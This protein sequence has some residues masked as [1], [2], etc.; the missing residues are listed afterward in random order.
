MASS[1]QASASSAVTVDESDADEAKP[2]ATRCPFCNDTFTE[3]KL[4]PCVHR[5]C[6]KCLVTWFES[7][8]DNPV[9]PVCKRSAITSSE[10]RKITAD[11]NKGGKKSEGEG[12]SD[13]GPRLAEAVVDTLPTDTVLAVLA[14][15]TRK[16][17]PPHVC[18]ACPNNQTHAVDLCMECGDMLCRGCSAVH[19]RLSATSTHKV[20]HVAD[21]SPEQLAKQVRETCQHHAGYLL[22]L[23]CPAHAQ[24]MCLMCFPIHHSQC[25]GVESVTDAAKRLRQALETQVQ[26]LADAGTSLAQSSADLHQRQEELR[27]S[28]VQVSKDTSYLMDRITSAVQARKAQLLKQAEQIPLPLKNKHRH[29]KEKVDEQHWVLSANQQLVLDSLRNASDANLLRVFGTLKARMTDLASQVVPQ[30]GGAMAPVHQ[31]AVLSVDQHD[32]LRIEELLKDLGLVEIVAR[33]K[34]STVEAFAV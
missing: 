18:S 31:R 15:S 23:Y 27:E 7:S 19:S 20:K 34:T 3:P 1:G 16:L 26:Q 13:T 8:T 6:R 32:V 33:D 4:L 2:A 10:Y 24:P 12:L 28:Q 22:E 30:S 25:Q 21:L 9:C 17:S 29:E 11:V 14:D 5:F